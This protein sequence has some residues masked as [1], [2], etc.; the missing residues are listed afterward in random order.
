MNEHPLDY[1][2]KDVIMANAANSCMFGAACR[3]RFAVAYFIDSF[4]IQC[5]LLSGL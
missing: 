5:P 3:Y 1:I 2:D 4:T